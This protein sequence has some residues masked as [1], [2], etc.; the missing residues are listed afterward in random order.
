MTPTKSATASPARASLHGS[1]DQTILRRAI[2]AI[3]ITLA[4]GNMIGRILAV[5][6]VDMIRLELNLIDRE[7]KSRVDKQVTELTAAGTPFERSELE[8]AT[9]EEV[10]ND[11]KIRKQRPFLSSNDRSRWATIRSLVEH[12]TYSIDEIVAEPNWDTI[13]MV[14]HKDQNGDRRLYSSKPPLLATLYAIAYWPIHKIT[15]ATLGSH[16]Y[17]IG[18]PLLIL[19]NVVPLIFVFV[20]LGAYSIASAAPIG[21]AFS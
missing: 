17:E 5:N 20:L 8:A 16:P 15:G 21:A 19:F 11:P 7:V 9:R 2:Y 4:T 18:R 14:Q 3:L 12:G 6:S 13:D 1:P 10:A